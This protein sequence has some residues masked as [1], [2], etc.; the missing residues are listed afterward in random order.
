[1]FSK[2]KLAIKMR[3]YIQ[4]QFIP[5]NLNRDTIEMKKPNVWIS[6]EMP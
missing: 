1:M 4:G 5:M 6:I 3:F 2:E